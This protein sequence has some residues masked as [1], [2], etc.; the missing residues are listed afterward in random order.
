ML[1]EATLLNRF[2]AASHLLL[3]LDSR[4]SNLRDVTPT[5]CASFY[6]GDSGPVERYHCLNLEFEDYGDR[7]ERTKDQW[8]NL[9]AG[10]KDLTSMME[11]N[12]LD[13]QGYRSPTIWPKWRS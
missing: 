2:R 12:M 3:A 11:F 6:I 1:L 7:F 4:F 8:L 5:Y 13:V 10:T 9:L